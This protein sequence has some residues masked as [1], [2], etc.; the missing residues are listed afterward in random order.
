MGGQGLP[1]NSPGYAT[2]KYSLIYSIF[3]DPDLGSVIK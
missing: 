3:N 1:S 2:E